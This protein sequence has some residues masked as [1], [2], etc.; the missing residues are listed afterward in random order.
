MTLYGL[1]LSAILAALAVGWSYYSMPLGDR[2][3]SDAHVALKPGGV[4]G[5][6]YGVVG[7]AMV[8]LLFL[9]SARKRRRFGLRFGR[10]NHW[11]NGHIFLGLVGPLLITLH[12]AMKFQGLVSIGFYSMLA[13]VLS[14]VF[15]R[16][17]YVQIPH[18]SAGAETALSEI[19]ES[20][21]ALEQ[22]L[23]EQYRASERTMSLIS[24]F[25]RRRGDAGRSGFRVLMSVLLDDFLR[26]FRLRKI[27]RSILADYSEIPAEAL[28]E[29]LAVS[30]RK[31]LLVRRLTYLKSMKSIFHLWHVIHKPFAYI[32]ILVM[33]IH[34]AVTI[35]FGYT[36]IF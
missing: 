20:N 3:H 2:P 9:Y 28:T 21:N 8:L 11:L 14:G 18:T 30:K 17:I 29:A 22:K 35:L 34:V 15:G 1:A 23:T 5:H 16:Y 36:W 6:G 19:E 24:S 4:W 10:M 12:T 33:F 13:V 7:S 27:R 32:M 25:G 31:A 26:P